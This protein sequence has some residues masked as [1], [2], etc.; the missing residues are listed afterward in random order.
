MM[1]KGVVLSVLASITFGVLYFY[2]EF[3]KPLNSEETFAWRM[4]AT[5]P[6]VT[7]LM[8][9]MGDLKLIS[10]IK[11]KKKKQPI[12]ILW[13]ILSSILCTSQLWLFLW[14]PING[15]GL[16]VS[17]GYFL[18]PLVM[19]LKLTKTTKHAKRHFWLN[20]VCTCHG[21]LPSHSA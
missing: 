16:Q 11:K 20:D 18:L 21:L 14:G 4:L 3:L 15:R 19:V 17:L 7:L 1:Y 5:I 2:T 10:D 8:W 9:W 6:F 13:L 12:L